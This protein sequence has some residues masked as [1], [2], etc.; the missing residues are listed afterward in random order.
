MQLQ[1]HSRVP[2]LDN[3]VTAKSFTHETQQP[4]AA[5]SFSSD[6]FYTLEV[7]LCWPDLVFVAGSEC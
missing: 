5:M 1:Q 3:F 4:L 7:A 2:L 6:M